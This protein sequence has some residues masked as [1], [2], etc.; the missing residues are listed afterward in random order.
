MSEYQTVIGLGNPGERH[1]YTR[2]NAGFL[3]V[4]KFCRRHR[5]TIWNIYG[6]YELCRMKMGN[7]TLEVIKPLTFM[8]LIGRAVGEYLL[9]TGIPARD[10]IVVH[11]DLDLEPGRVKVKIAGGSGGHKGLESIMEKVGSAEFT[12]VRLGIGK[13]PGEMDPADYVLRPPDSPD[14]I[15]AFEAG[16]IL[17]VDALD[18]VIFQGAI[19]AMNRYNQ[20]S[21]GAECPGANENGNSTTEEGQNE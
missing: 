2:H 20:Q 13:P 15:R 17:A 12:R 18:M 21:P 7:R 8:N 1:R 16:I 4:E 9:K 11:D 3:I 19:P 10:L 14:E 6:Q 5:G